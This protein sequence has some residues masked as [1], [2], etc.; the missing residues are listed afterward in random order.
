MHILKSVHLVLCWCPS[1]GGWRVKGHIMSLFVPTNFLIIYPK[2]KGSQKSYKAANGSKPMDKTIIII[3][4]V[5]TLLIFSFLTL[6][7]WWLKLL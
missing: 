1:F 6:N 5:Q 7:L 4:E 2:P 3:D